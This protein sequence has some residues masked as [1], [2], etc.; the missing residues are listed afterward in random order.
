MRKFIYIGFLLF[1]FQATYSQNGTIEKSFFNLQTG[2]LGTWINNETRIAKNV[3]LRT[4]IGFDAGIF[5]GEVNNNS[6]LFLA[7]VISLEPRWYYNIN[8]RANKNKNTLNNSANFI[9]PLISYHPDWFVISNN[10]VSVFNQVSII[11]KWGIRRSIAETNFNLEA[12][13]G[14]GYRYYFK[15]QYG[16]LKNDSE[17]AL[18]LHF[19][20][21]YTFKKTKK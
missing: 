6:G 18:D 16:Y 21:G 15:K 12:G 7:P 14:I 2:V 3:A 17:I 4:E 9:T 8:K 13:I 1:V 20:I 19:R 10:N 5:G 11:P